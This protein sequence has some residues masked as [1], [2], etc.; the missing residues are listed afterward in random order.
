MDTGLKNK[1]VLVTGSTAGIGR[2]IAIAFGREGAKVGVTYKNNKTAA[3][4]TASKV[5]EAGGEALV[6]FYD[7]ADD[8]SIRAAVQKLKENWGTI[9]V[10][11]NNAVKWL[12]QEEA[13]EKVLFEEVPPAKWRDR[14][15][16]SLEGAYFTIQC[17]VPMMRA[18]NWGRIVNISSNIAED[19]I[20]GAAAYAAAKAGLHGLTRVLAW[21]LGPVGILTNVVM[22]GL[23]ITERAKQSIPAE[24]LQEKA[25]RIPTGRL[26]T[27]EDIA[28]LVVFLGSAANT[29][30][31]GEMIR[32]T[33]GL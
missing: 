18:Q 11:V 25:S 10:L 22:P 29:H 33:G 23:T 17:V 24:I 7:L 26:S 21:E 31:N 20:V 6:V 15:R 13:K 16:S 27:P 28:P 32:V 1:V 30:V 14:I 19:G 12:H 2:A 5:I 9:H 3:E 4:E 8:D